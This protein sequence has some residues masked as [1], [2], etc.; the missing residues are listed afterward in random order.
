MKYTIFEIPR[1]YWLPIEDKVGAWVNAG[2]SGLEE[3]K[4]EWFT[5][6]WKAM[7]PKEMI[8]NKGSEGA[9]TVVR[10]EKK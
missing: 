9:E 2:W 8:P 5:D 7:V 10:E 3:E 4:P 1:E 6:N